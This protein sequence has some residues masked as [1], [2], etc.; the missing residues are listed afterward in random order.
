[1]VKRTQTRDELEGTQRWAT[2]Q[3]G[4][5]DGCIIR[6]YSVHAGGSDEHTTFTKMDV[7]ELDRL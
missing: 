4:G 1:M 5:D 3:G 7:G 2:C 6:V